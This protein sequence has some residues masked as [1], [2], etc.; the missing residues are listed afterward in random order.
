MSKSNLDDILGASADDKDKTQITETKKA[1]AKNDKS[2]VDESK[3]TKSTAKKEVKSA[4]DKKDDSKEAAKLEEASKTVT[5]ET[6]ESKAEDSQKS[7]E[8]KNQDKTVTSSADES[9]KAEE[10]KKPEP[11]LEPDDKVVTIQENED[12]TETSIKSQSEFPYSLALNRPVVI[13]RGA[14]LNLASKSFGGTV[15]ILGEDVDGF[16]PVEYVRSEIGLRRGYILTRE[17][18]EVWKSLK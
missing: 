8:T 17:V 6:Q 16:T 5:N 18:E 11:E 4:D 13:Y 10:D 15:R 1:E 9:N 12:K 3:A 14:S 2:S 7:A